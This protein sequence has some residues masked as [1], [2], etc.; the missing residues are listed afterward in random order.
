MNAF[1]ERLADPQLIALYD[2]WDGLR[3]GR[4]MPSRR[5][6]DPAQF[7]ALLPEIMLVDVTHDPLRLRYR[8]MGARTIVA[9]RE[10]RTGRYFD[11]VAEFVQDPA[12]LAPFHAVA[13]SRMPHY[14][15]E[16]VTDTSWSVSHEIVRLIL[17]LSTEGARVDV[18]LV[19]LRL[20]AVP[21]ADG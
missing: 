7:T 19:C 4:A 11:E 3:R 15:T 20:R 8:L 14:A 16:F 9:A 10:N 21:K 12:A 18:L 6:L 5:D 13:G 1:R 2:Y 17:P